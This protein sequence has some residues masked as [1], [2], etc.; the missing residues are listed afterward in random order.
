MR[1]V[2]FAVLW[3]F[4]AVEARYY[5][6]AYA[7]YRKDDPTTESTPL[8]DDNDKDRMGVLYRS[9]RMNQNIFRSK[10]NKIL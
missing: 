1:L 10:I 9:V 7:G 3:S 8:T 2:C 5:H 4:V 6:M